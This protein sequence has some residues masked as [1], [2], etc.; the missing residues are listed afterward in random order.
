MNSVFLILFTFIAYIVAYL[1]YGKY[2]GKKIFNLDNS[3]IT[4]A[5]ELRDNIDYMPAKKFVLF[6]HHFTS[7]AGLGPIV[8]PTIAVIWGVVP[9]ILWVVFGS[10]F[11][12]AVHDIGS[13]VVSMRNKGMSIGEITSKLV[14][15]RTRLL[16]LLI[17][18]FELWM[19]IAVFALIIA[20]LFTMYPASVLPVWLQIPIS[21]GVGF[22]VYKKGGSINIASIIA[23][24]LMYLTIVLGTKYPIILPEFFKL[25]GT[26]S[27]III[28]FIYAFIASIL[29]VW[30]LLQPRDY[31]NALQL[32]IILT[33]LSLGLF[34]SHPVVVAPMVQL[35]PQGAPPLIPF[36]FIIIAC[37][38]ISG[39]HSLVA[40]GTTGKQIDKEED[41]V[42]IG[43]GSMLAEGALAALVI[44]AVTA[45]IGL[46]TGEGIGLLKGNEAWLHHYSSWSAIQGLGAKLS[47][48]VT[49]AVNMIESLGIPKNLAATIFGV[50]LVSF[51]NTTL[52]TAA[53]IQRYVI[54]ELALDYNIKFLSG[55]YKST[56]AAIATAAVLAFSNKGGK[57]ALVLW[58]LFGSVNQ[59]LSGL[60]LLI[61]TVYL[62]KKGSKIWI[63]ALPM[64]FMIIMTGYAM[65]YNILDFYQ[66]NNIL[67][68]LTG[69]LVFVLEIWM[70]IEASKIL[71]KDNQ[72]I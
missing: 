11:M 39:F 18:F 54:S 19:V 3:K 63:T 15:K 61:I 70:V 24:V 62:K 22:Y 33:L 56:F 47:A 44:A 53:R 34:V 6:G 17:I 35:H 42:F 67:L 49:G 45:G 29:P 8:G 46:G 12:G 69:V 60:A 51:A 48:F 16:F 71:L 31:I 68:L 40:S 23:I 41:A 21:M 14:N 37:G 25:S 28:L 64:I 32:I 72:K 55:K 38:A 9:A 1:V 13:L 2:L 65:G 27:W 57:G 59:L 10:I 30:T 5:H 7:I 58:P 43:Y 36:L 50:F 26:E 20:I 52:D 66:K 4:P